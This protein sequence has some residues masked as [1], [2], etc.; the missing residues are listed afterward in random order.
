MVAHA[1]NGDVGLE[2]IGATMVAVAGVTGVAITVRLPATPREVVYAS[3]QVATELEELILT[4][5]EGP[6]VDALID[7]P[8]LV[9]DLADAECAARWPA[10]TDAEWRALRN[11]CK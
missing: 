2:H 3:D 11:V 1:G 9:S 8:V 10:F 5:G 4:L 6:S 7:G